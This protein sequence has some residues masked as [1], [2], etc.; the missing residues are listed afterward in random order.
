MMRSR[1]VFPAPLRPIKRQ[2]GAGLG[3]KDHVAQCGI[4]AIILPDAFSGDRVHGFLSAGNAGTRK[5]RRF[6]SRRR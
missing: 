6:L 5:L 2:A 4:V 1:V 3:V